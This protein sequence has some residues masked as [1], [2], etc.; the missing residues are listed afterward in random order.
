MNKWI[1]QEKT[2]YIIIFICVKLL[3]NLGIFCNNK[4]DCK[5]DDEYCNI[6]NNWLYISIIKYNLNGIFFSYLFNL[7]EKGATKLEYKNKCPYYFYQK[8][9][10]EPLAIVMLNIF[11]S[12]IGVIKDSLIDHNE[13]MKCTCQEFVDK[14][15]TIYRHVNNKYCSSNMT[16]LI[17]RE[18]K[19]C[20]YLKNF[21][22]TYD[23]YL[24]NHESIQNQKIYVPSLKHEGNLIFP[25]C[26][27]NDG[28]Q[29][30]LGIVEEQLP[31]DEHEDLIE[32]QLDDALKLL[33]DSESFISSSSI[34]KVLPTSLA[35]I[36]CFTPIG[37]MIRSSNRVKATSN[38]YDGDDEKELLYPVHDSMDINSYI[39]RYDIAY[40]NL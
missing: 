35:T 11:E 20:L 6:L 36:A 37:N 17:E 24:K 32:Q 21:E 31:D 2:H 22:T 13:V 18:K 33:P 14:V 1:S 40:A 39:Q 9:Y 10:V 28:V 23:V 3:K 34:K 7:I 26:I 15:V 8:N 4:Q 5:N 30:P 12:N 25:Q 29:Q 38:F 16:D 27:Q 19:T